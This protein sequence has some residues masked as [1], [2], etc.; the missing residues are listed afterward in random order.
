MKCAHEKNFKSNLLS[1][2]YWF[3]PKFVKIKCPPP[4]KHNI[5]PFRCVFIGDMFD[6]KLGNEIVCV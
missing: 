6:I 2:K 3:G 1:V 5:M 4:E